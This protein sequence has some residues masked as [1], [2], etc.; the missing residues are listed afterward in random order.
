MKD[1]RSQQELGQFTDR[2][3]WTERTRPNAKDKYDQTPR[4][5]AGANLYNTT[6]SSFMTKDIVHPSNISSKSGNM[7]KKSVATGG[8]QTRMA[9]PDPAEAVFNRLT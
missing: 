3:A 4:A 6:T 7:M 1:I 8:T 2:E 9:S 5:A